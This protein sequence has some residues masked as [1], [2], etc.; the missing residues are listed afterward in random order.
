MNM[1]R[2]I[3]AAERRM[4]K[5]A[6]R[7][8]VLSFLSSILC[9]V[10]LVSCASTAK[11]PPPPPRYV[12]HNRPAEETRMP[13]TGSNSLYRDTAS[14]YEDVKAHRLNDLITINVV[15]NI[16]GSGTADTTASKAATYNNGITNLL[17]IPTNLN[18]TNAYGRG[19]TFAPTV[20]ASTAEDFKGAGATDRAGSL[21]GTITA[22]VVEVMPNGVLA[23]EARKELTINNEKQILILRGMVQPD[24]IAV[25]NSVLSNRVA[26]A[27][28]F[29]VGDGVLNGKQ[30]EGWFVKL[31]DKVWPF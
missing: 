9:T 20:N 2:K 29:F 10:M 21:T 8:S 3:L 30:D 25:D 6:H 18:L 26:D 27:E 13:V 5:R 1:R 14:L 31:M 28:V 17:G 7:S 12:Y 15:E 24:D 19:N 11:L 23:I 22:K 4:E 16:S